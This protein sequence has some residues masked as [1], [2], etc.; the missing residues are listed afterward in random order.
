MEVPLAKVVRTVGPE[1][2]KPLVGTTAPTGEA[3]K[4]SA[5]VR[6]RPTGLLYQG[7]TL[8]NLVPTDENPPGFQRP[9]FTTD[10]RDPRPDRVWQVHGETPIMCPPEAPW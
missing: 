2:R 4:A 6:R 10:A 8:G 9:C 3:K 7:E 1:V 5:R